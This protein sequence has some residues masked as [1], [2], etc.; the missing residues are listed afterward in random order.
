MIDGLDR[1][2]IDGKLVAASGGATFETVNPA[3]EEVL[4]VA[5][6]G[7]A[8]DLDAAIG[9]ARA[10]FD[11]GAPEW[12][13]P[14]FRATRAR[15]RRSWIWARTSCARS[16]SSCAEETSRPFDS[17]AFLSAASASARRACADRRATWYG[18]SSMTIRSWPFLTIAP[19]TAITWP[20]GR[21]SSSLTVTRPEPQ[22]ASRTVS[23][24]R[25]ASRSRSASAQV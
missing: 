7:T 5:A 13:D 1:N 25:S 2:L 17:S 12:A 21:R 23:S 22:P 6:D 16:R 11:G 9:A 10:A 18:S 20:R 3:T 14:A 8:A 4:G 15:F 19:S 24:P